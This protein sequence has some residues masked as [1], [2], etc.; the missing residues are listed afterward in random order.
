MK[1]RVY[2]AKAIE[3]LKKLEIPLLKDFNFIKNRYHK[4]LVNCLMVT[5]ITAEMIILD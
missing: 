4:S 3:F 1:E 2:I 5:N